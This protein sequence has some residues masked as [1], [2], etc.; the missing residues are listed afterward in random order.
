[1]GLAAE[2][3]GST[4]AKHHKHVFKKMDQYPLK[5]LV[6]LEHVLCWGTH[7]Q[8]SV[9]LIKRRPC[10]RN[11]KVTDSHWSRMMVY[12]A[13]L[14]GHVNVVIVV[15]ILHSTLAHQSQDGAWKRTHNR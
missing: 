5:H 7:K 2:V 15:W 9:S 8:G 13:P 14:I 10:G 4:A 11:M 12:C 1:V 6:L 3:F